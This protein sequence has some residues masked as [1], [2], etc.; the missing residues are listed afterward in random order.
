MLEF[1]FLVSEKFV[2]YKILNT[3]KLFRF[4][5]DSSVLPNE[6]VQIFYHD[7]CH[8]FVCIADCQS[9]RNLKPI[10][11]QIFR[12]SFTTGNFALYMSTM[13]EE[14]VCQFQHKLGDMT[15]SD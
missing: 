15:H 7:I 1:I 5:V 2:I 8:F 6:G 10:L 14:N 13:L 12:V 9:S 3:L 4:T 11:F